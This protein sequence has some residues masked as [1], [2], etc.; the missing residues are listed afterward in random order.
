M[1]NGGLKGLKMKNMAILLVLLAPWFGYAAPNSVG[2][3]NVRQEI[4]VPSW[5]WVTLP[6]STIRHLRNGARPLNSSEICGI[7]VAGKVVILEFSPDQKSAL[8]SYTAPVTRWVLRAGLASHF[9]C[10]YLT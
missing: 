7:E 3:L 2:E 10:L 8:V 9:I 1:P 5:R 6:N 4:H